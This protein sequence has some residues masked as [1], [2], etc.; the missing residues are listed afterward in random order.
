MARQRERCGGG[1]ATS[2]C[3]A[4]CCWRLHP[5]AA[6]E[7]LARDNVYIGYGTRDDAYRKDQRES[8]R[9]PQNYRNGRS[10]IF[11]S[12]ASRGNHRTPDESGDPRL[13]HRQ[14][15]CFS[16]ARV[17]RTGRTTRSPRSCRRDLHV[18]DTTPVRI[19][20]GTGDIVTTGCRSTSRSRCGCRR[21]ITSTSRTTR[22]QHNN[23]TDM[24]HGARRQRPLLHRL[25]LYLPSPAPAASRWRPAS[26]FWMPEQRR[27]ASPATA[28]YI[29]DD[30]RR[31]EQPVACRR[32]R[33]GR[34]DRQAAAHR[35]Q[36]RLQSDAELPEASSSLYLESEAGRGRWRTISRPMPATAAS[37]RSICSIVSIQR[38]NQGT[39][40]LFVVARAGAGL[41][42]LRARAAGA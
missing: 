38:A 30:G 42:Q 40:G 6:S 35:D 26:D 2:R 37:C 3:W 9:W 18:G 21:A 27:T 5:P 10:G 22:I 17:P 25:R 14:L 28:S 39:D 4:E 8:G 15:G 16:R 41:R 32:R 33:R 11:M 7:L 29:Y 12:Q 20:A 13:S 36:H 1:W 24:S 34:R 31:A 23:P 19:Y